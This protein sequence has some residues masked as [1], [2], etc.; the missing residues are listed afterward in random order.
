MAEMLPGFLLDILTF[1]VTP[2]GQIA[3]ALADSVTPAYSNS[4]PLRRGCIMGWE[5]QLG[6]TGTKA[7]KVELEQSNVRPAV[8]GTAD[9]NW[10]IPDNKVA[11]PLY[12]DITDVLK[13]QVAYAPNPTGFG[14]LKFTGLVGNDP[15]TVVTAARVYALKNI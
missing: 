15:S 11:T 12:A 8:E 9:V 4:F 5:I 3:V 1:G 7:V 13:H 14:R 10:V 6:G 2:I